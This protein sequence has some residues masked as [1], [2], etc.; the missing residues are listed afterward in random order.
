MLE[1]YLKNQ[2]VSLLAMAL[3]FII[4]CLFFKKTMAGVN[5]AYI[6]TV[7]ILQLFIDKKTSMKKILAVQKRKLSQT[8][9]GFTMVEVMV[10]MSI[11]ILLALFVAPELMNWPRN[12]RLKR[13]ITDLQMNFQKAKLEAIRRNSNVVLSFTTVACPGLPSKV[14]TNGGSYYIF[15]DDG[16][17]GGTAKDN[18]WTPPAGLNPGEERFTITG[19]GDE[20]TPNVYE[21]PGNTALCQTGSG[22]VVK[23]TFPRT[24][25]GFTSRGLVIVD[26]TGVADIGSLSIDGDSDDPQGKNYTLTLT[27]AGGITV[28]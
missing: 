4:S 18:I 11:V 5:L 17:G 2:V 21:M 12:M 7:S 13:A 6:C 24:M 14:P 15:I 3:S 10:V 28:Q 19:D 23:Y 9:S 20:S 8:Q 27:V 1:I 16:A 26:G 25:T 22:G